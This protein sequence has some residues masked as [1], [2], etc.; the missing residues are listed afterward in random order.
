[1][2]SSLTILFFLFSTV[3]TKQH[4]SDCLLLLMN[5]HNIGSRP[6]FLPKFDS[7]TFLMMHILLIREQY[8]SCDACGPM[9][10][11]FQYSSINILQLLIIQQRKNW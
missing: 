3:F 10:P 8:G 2:F 1:M 11:S 4:T 6:G 9:I 5:N 7:R